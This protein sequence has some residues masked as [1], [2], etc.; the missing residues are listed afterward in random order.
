MSNN[1]ARL[2]FS[3][4]VLVVFCAGLASGFVLGRHAPRATD[5][6]ALGSGGRGPGPL[7]GPGR[8][9]PAGGMLFDRLDRELQLTPD[10]KTQVRTIFNERRTRL[11][12]VQR[13]VLARAGQERRDLQA[14]IRQVLTPEQ[15]QKFDRWLQEQPRGR[16][17]RGF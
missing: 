16:R 15:Q 2:W 12:N 1:R 3:L 13:E 14:E 8:G 5:R 17:G 10:Q 9:G 6:L 7:F 4:F 11:E